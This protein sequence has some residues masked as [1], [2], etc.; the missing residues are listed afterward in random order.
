MATETDCEIEHGFVENFV[1]LFSLRDKFRKLR[2][3]INEN[4]TLENVKGEFESFGELL[5]VRET[6]TESLFQR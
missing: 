1:Q 6:G 2:Y 5:S 3:G 4:G